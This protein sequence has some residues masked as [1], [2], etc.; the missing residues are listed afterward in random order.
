MI[1]LE[2]SEEQDTRL[3]TEPGTGSCPG[4]LLVLHWMVKSSDSDSPVPTWDCC[5]L[6]SFPK[7]SIYLGW[8][9]NWFLYISKIYLCPSLLLF[10]VTSLVSCF[11]LSL[12]ELVTFLPQQKLFLTYFDI[13]KTD[14]KFHKLW[15]QLS[16]HYGIYTQI[17]CLLSPLAP[18]VTSTLKR[19]S[20]TLLPLKQEVFKT[21]TNLALWKYYSRE[22]SIWQAVCTQ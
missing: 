18:L 5:L 16:R 17:G 20:Q 15:G 9:E 11:F 14:G 3:G 6:A 13:Q 12:K 7:F 2:Q 4:L 21:K 19:W 22:G 1:G 8:M 10:F